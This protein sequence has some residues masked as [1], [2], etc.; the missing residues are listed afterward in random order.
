M[1]RIPL[2]SSLAREVYVSFLPEKENIRHGF[3]GAAR[4]EGRQSAS[5]GKNRRVAGVHP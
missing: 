3:K 4:E 5:Q 2:F 1:N